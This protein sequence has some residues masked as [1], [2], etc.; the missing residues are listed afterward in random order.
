MNTYLDLLLYFI[1][2]SFLGWIMETVFA[3]FKE[4]KFVNRGFLSGFFCPIYGFGAILIIQSSKWLSVAIENHAASLF[5]NILLSIFLVTVLEYITG[6][7]LE[8]IFNC[9]W[10]DYSDNAAHIKGYICI[11]Y[12][13][14][15]GLLAILLVQIVHPVVTQIVYLIPVTTKGT[16]ALLFLI[17]VMIDTR[18]SVIDALSLRKVILN[19]SSISINKYYQYILKYKRFFIAFPNLL[20][21]NAGLVN[22]NIRSIIND[23]IV[24][25]K[26]ELRSRFQ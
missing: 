19:Y 1:I 6:A 18:K 11:K 21:L 24:K 3:S 26:T 2:Y 10:W 12:S 9:K 4:K 8:K 22:H 17:Y 13:I 14:L 23:R 7:L 15:W 5:V 20:I 25:I 16:M